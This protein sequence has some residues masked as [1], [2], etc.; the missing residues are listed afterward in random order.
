MRRSKAAADG[1]V[2]WAVRLAV[3]GRITRVAYGIPVRELY[4][5]SNLEH[6]G[7]TF[8]RRPQGDYVRGRWYEMIGKVG[9]FPAASRS[10]A[11]HTKSRMSF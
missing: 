2:I 1:A 4:D 11:K 8:T 7:R 5:Y 10:R 6:H 9:E 3:V